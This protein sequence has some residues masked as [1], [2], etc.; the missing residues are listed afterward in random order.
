MSRRIAVKILVSDKLLELGLMYGMKLFYFFTLIFCAF[1]LPHI[2]RVLAK[3][4]HVLNFKNRAVI[5][6]D[7]AVPFAEN[8]VAD[9]ADKENS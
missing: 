1:S 8:L 4:N 6:R 3:C 9:I 5:K 7:C 2:I